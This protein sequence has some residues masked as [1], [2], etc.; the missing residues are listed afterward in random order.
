MVIK[1]KKG[2]IELSMSTIVILVLA[3]SMLVLGI[4]LIKNIFSSGTN[5]IKSVD[6]GVKSEIQK[7]FSNE[8][9]KIV[10]YPTS[11]L[12][13]IKQGADGEGFAFSV[14]NVDSGAPKSF[15][16]SVRADTNFSYASK[17][18]GITAAIAND[19]IAV[20]SGSFT[21]SSG[22]SL[23]NEIL[24]LFTIPRTVPLCSIPFNIQI[25][26]GANS[27]AFTNIYL[28]IK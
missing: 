8:G 18:P 25:K 19:W 28:R 22:N 15:T 11:R 12:V 10:V 7:I 13:D 23:D 3:M 24:V 6:A 1:S 5:A 27:Y 4:I 21:L 17:C 26:D 9:S 20:S 14:K 2:A 16:W